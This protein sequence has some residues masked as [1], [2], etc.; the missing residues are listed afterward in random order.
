MF[1]FCI[2]VLFLYL[3][4][5]VYWEEGVRKGIRSKIIDRILFIVYIYLEGGTEYRNICDKDETIGFFFDY[6]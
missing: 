2:L 3:Y 5:V 1:N 4:S 6:F